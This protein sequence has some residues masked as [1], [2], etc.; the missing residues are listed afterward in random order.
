M[1]KRTSRSRPAI[2]SEET[3]VERFTRVVT[4]RVGKAVKAIRTIGFCASGTYEYT[5][6][7]VLE[8]TN[9]LSKQIHNL[10]LKFESKSGMEEEFTFGS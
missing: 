5:P 6:E 3:K 4:P 1:G 10:K 8:I 2:S 7:Q 9:A